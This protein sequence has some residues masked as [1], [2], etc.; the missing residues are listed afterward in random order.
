[1]SEKIIIVDSLDQLRFFGVN[2]EYLKTI[3]KFFPKL[4]IVSRGSEVKVIGTEEVIDDFQE[5]F[6]LLLNYYEKYNQLDQEAIAEI[7]GNN[8]R[9]FI[10]QRN[11]AN[12]DVIVYGN[13]GL[14]VKPRTQTQIKLVEACN[15][16]DLVF[17][18]GPA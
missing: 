5:K 13:D 2:N 16:E 17:A 7:C 15:N 8:N 18:I 9:D 10:K 1:L 3:Q 14:V 6:L 12:S 4:Q 11:P